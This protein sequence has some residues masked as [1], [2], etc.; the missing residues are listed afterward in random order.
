MKFGIA[1]LGLS[2]DP[3]VLPDIKILGLHDEFT[4]FSTLAILHLSEE[5]LDHLW[6][7]AQKVDG[8]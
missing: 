2:K 5:P 6:D 4:I 7:L 1:L 3:L 8:W